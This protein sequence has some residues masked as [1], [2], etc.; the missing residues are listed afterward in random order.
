ML[1]DT[2]SKS[3]LILSY[4]CKFS[5]VYTLDL[6]SLL[7]SGWKFKIWGLIFFL[8]GARQ[9]NLT[10][11]LDHFKKN[12]SLKKGAVHTKNNGIKQNTKIIVS[13]FLKK[14]KNKSKP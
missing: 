8:K 1:Q 2:S 13:M 6:R 7:H 14:S 11:V 9:L 12:H 3:A 10:L 5:F 4:L